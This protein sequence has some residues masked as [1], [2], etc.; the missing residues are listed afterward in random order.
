LTRRGIKLWLHNLREA[1]R[2]Q[3][4]GYHYRYEQDADPR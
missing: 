3:M 1:C 2:D 4:E